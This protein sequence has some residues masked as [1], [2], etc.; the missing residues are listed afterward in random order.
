MPKPLAPLKISCTDSKCD[1][2]LHCF[3][4]RAQM[5]EQE[6]GRCRDCGIDVVDWEVAHARDIT[7]AT[8]LFSELPK[9]LIRHHYWDM[10]IPQPIR[11]KALRYRPDVIAD[12]THK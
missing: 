11:D 7:R 3:R 4:P 5:T 12:R 8:E 10:E 6:R 1:A 9:E 2:D